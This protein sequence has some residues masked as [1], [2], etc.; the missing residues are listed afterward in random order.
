MNAA[1]ALVVARIASDLKEGVAVARSAI[2]RGEAQAKLAKFVEFNGS[3]E[4]LIEA[5]KRFL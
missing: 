5:E 2:K 1:A 3:A 4:K